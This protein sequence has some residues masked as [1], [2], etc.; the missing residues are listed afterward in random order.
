MVFL[1]YT[2]THTSAVYIYVSFD[3]VSALEDV[4]STAPSNYSKKTVNKLADFMIEYTSLKC[5][6][7]FKTCC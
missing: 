5:N 3:K 2:S 1:E 4:M 6:V 7:C